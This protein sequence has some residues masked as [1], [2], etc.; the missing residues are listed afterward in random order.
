MPR[1]YYSFAD[2]SATDRDRQDSYTCP[3]C[4]AALPYHPIFL[5]PDI[6]CSDCGAYLWCGRRTH[7]PIMVLEMLAGRI[8]SPQD[9][10]QVVESLLDSGDVRRVVVNMSELESL[11][12]AF[13]ARLVSLNK[14]IRGAGRRLILCELTPFVREVLG[15]L[16]LD[17]LFEIVD[18]ETDA[19]VP[20]PPRTASADSIPTSPAEKAN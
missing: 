4:G 15:R 17:A 1:A 18:R 13:T 12:S 8:P 3:V 20:E 5:P 14:Q 2:G 10:D 6:P 9:V 11:N 19:T 16:R 7:G